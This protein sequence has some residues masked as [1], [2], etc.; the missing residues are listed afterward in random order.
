VELTGVSAPR[1]R[2]G[3]GLLRPQFVLG[4]SAFPGDDGSLPPAAST[5][6][7]A[8]ERFRAFRREPG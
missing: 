6:E 5:R 3:G 8:V 7:F 2:L 4:I 1:Y